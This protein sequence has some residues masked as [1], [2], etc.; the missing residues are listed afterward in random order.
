MHESMQRDD[1][2]LPKKRCSW[3]T[4]IEELLLSV[5]VHDRPRNRSEDDAGEHALRRIVAAGRGRQERRELANLLCDRKGCS[6]R[7]LMFCCWS[8]GHEQASMLQRA[9]ILSSMSRVAPEVDVG[10]LADVFTH[11]V[12][13]MTAAFDFLTVDV[14]G[15]AGHC[16]PCFPE[17]RPVDPLRLSDNVQVR[18]PL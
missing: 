4:S 16:K 14:V 1:S 3:W 9:V 2:R 18:M 15:V 13:S 17:R 7:R 8:E 10:W 12:S 6:R 5:L 11:V